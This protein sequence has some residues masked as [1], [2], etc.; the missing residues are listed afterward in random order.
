M[1]SLPLRFVSNHLVNLVELKKLACFVFLWQK[2]RNG[3][4]NSKHSSSRRIQ[5]TAAD[6]EQTAGR[7]AKV[8]RAECFR[9]HRLYLVAKR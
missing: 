8:E 3:T 7:S 6:F 4:E 9:V 1:L 5:S 2:G